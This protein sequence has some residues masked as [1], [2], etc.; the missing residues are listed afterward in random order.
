MPSH[1][2]PIPATAAEMFPAISIAINIVFVNNT[3]FLLTKSRGLHYGTAKALA[4]RQEATIKTAL[5]TV[6]LQ[7]L[8]QGFHI[9][10]IHAN[11]EFEPL[12]ATFLMI[13]MCDQDDHIPD[14]KQFVQTVKDCACSTY[15][16]LPFCR[17][18][19]L[20]L[21]HLV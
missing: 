1:I 10:S 9:G 19:R 4:N 6:C 17:L 14:A 3:P 8:S 7:Y 2:E 11:P 5:K 18:P 13:H 12:W 20:M 16:M 21:T 15:W